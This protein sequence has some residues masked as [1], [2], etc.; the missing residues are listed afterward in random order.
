MLI[1]S[2]LAFALASAGLL[3]QSLEKPK[4]PQPTGNVVSVPTAIQESLHAYATLEIR[5][6]DAEGR[7]LKDSVAVAYPAS[8]HD[9]FA[10][11]RTVDA[12]EPDKANLLLPLPNP[13]LY[14][15]RAG[16]P[17]HRRVEVPVV[18]D[19][20]GSMVLPVLRPTPKDP[21]NAKP[22][23]DDARTLRW[24]QIWQG[25]VDRKMKSN[26][27]FAQAQQSKANHYLNEVRVL[28]AD[29]YQNNWGNDLLGL[30]K[31]MAREKDKLTRSLLAG[32]Y[33]DI[34]FDG[35]HL[36]PTAV[37]MALRHLPEDSPFWSLSPQ[38]PYFSYQAAGEMF[39]RG[40]WLFLSRI[41][42]KNPDSEVRAY[43]LLRRIEYHDSRGEADDRKRLGHDLLKT[44]SGTLAA[45]YLPSRFPHD[46]E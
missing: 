3:A 8:R 5:L 2:I 27:G 24:I 26:A 31:E 7:P 36:N 35:S 12:P 6:V 18:V 25:Y 33:L 22:V 30:S 28:D 17:N 39:R 21:Q 38:M 10:V 40:I 44:Y 34:G 37:D 9:L 15:L 42:K 16:A 41:E 19:K 14:I 23:C 45:G 20:A 32:C 29:I 43:A 4:E 13:G 1:R 11:A 46:F